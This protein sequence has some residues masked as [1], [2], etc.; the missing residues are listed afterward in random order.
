MEPRYV[1]EASSRGELREAALARLSF[2]GRAVFIKM[3]KT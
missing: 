1:Y 2:F 3:Q